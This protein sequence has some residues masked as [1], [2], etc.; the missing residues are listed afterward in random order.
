MVT[1]DGQASAPVD[2]PVSALNPG[3]Y[4]IDGTQAV[5][6]H[7]ADYGLAT[8]ARPAGEHWGSRVRRATRG[9]GARVLWGVR[10]EFSGGSQDLVVT[11]DGVAAP[12]VKVAVE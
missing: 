10:G 5:A 8:T 2:V 4:R 3:V 7:G 6:V 9:V 11:A 12:V 1:R